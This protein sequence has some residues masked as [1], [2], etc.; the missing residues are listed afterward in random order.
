MTGTKEFILLFL[1]LR[2]GFQVPWL[3]TLSLNLV[4]TGFNILKSSLEVKINPGIRFNI[5][6]LR[7]GAARMFGSRRLESLLG[8]KHRRC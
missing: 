5:L 2:F 8:C 1:R 7:K 3:G 4:R 6:A